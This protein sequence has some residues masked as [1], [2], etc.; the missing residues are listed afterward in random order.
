MSSGAGEVPRRRAGVSPRKVFAERLTA[1]F[2]AAGSPTLRSVASAAAARMAAAGGSN[3]AT[4]QRISDWRTGKAVPAEF[5]SLL[6][7]LLTLIEKATKAGAPA[8]ELIKLPAWKA[9]WRAAQARGP[10]FETACPYLGLTAYGPGDREW[11]FGRTRATAEIADLL[12]RTVDGPDAGPVV[13]IGASGAGK[14]S[15]L[16]AGVIPALRADRDWSVASMTPGTRP[17]KTLA[18][19][20]DPPGDAAERPDLVVIDQF[21]ETFTLCQDEPER[22]RFLRALAT[23]H[24]N[25]RTAVIL[26]VRADFYPHCLAYPVLED[27][28]N[29]RCYALGPMRVAELG[30]AITGPAQAAGLNFEPGLPELVVTELCGLGAGHDRRSYDPGGLPL[31]SHVMATTW[32]HRAG[33]RLTVA[34]YRKAGGVAGSVA[35]TAEQAWQALSSAEQ[36]AAKELLLHL[37]TVGVDSRDTRRRVPRAELLTRT[38]NSDA[39]QTALIRL[40]DAR[41]I[42]ADS[43]GVAEPATAAAPT[44]IAER[45]VAAAP[46]GG[47]EPES[48]AAREIVWFTHEIV[49][50]AWPRL[51]AWIDEGRVDHLIR[52]RLELDAAEWAAAQRDP[53]LLY[54]G[55]RLTTAEQAGETPGGVIGEFLTAAQT[56]RTRTRRL[57]LATRSVLALLGVGVLV[58][59]IAAYA[60]TRLSAQEHE[61]ADLV[62]TLA[63]ADSVRGTDPSLS[64]QLELVADRLHPGD[65]DIRSRLLRTQNLP[66]SAPLAGHRGAV[67][68]VVYRPDGRVLASA[69]QDG[70][71]RMWDVADLA[72]ATPLG[73]PL[74]CGNGSTATVFSPDGRLLAA[75]CGTEIRLWNVADPAHPNQLAS[76]GAGKVSALAIGPD[77]KTL[78]ATDGTNVTLWSIENPSAPVQ[79]TRLPSAGPVPAIAFG[80]GGLAVAGGHTVQFWSPGP[81]T[82]ALGAPITVPGPEIQAMAMSRDGTT[83]AV[84]GGDDA[85]VATG[86][87]DATVTLWDL[88][89]R[90]P[91]QM[92]S[93]L[94]VTTKSEL[95]SLAFDPEGSILATGDRDNVTLWSIVDRAHPTRLG[96]PLAAPSPPCPDASNFQPCRDSPS[97][98][99]FAADGHTVAVGGAQGGL[100]LWSL[101]PAVI[102]GRIGWSANSG[103]L[104]A[105]GTMATSVVDGRIELWDIHDRQSVRLLADLGPGPGRDFTGTPSLSD[106]GRLT[107]TTAGPHAGVQLLDVGDPAHVRSL[108]RFPDA[109]AGWFG[110]GGRVLVTLES[111]WGA[112]LWDLSDPA[113]PVAISPLIEIG[114][115]PVGLAG[116]AIPHSGHLMVTLAPDKNAAGA[117][118]YLI[119]LWDITHRGSVTELDR[120]AGDPAHPVGA[121]GLTPD[122]RTM[123]TLSANTLRIWDISDPVQAHPLGEPII[124]HAFNIQSVDFSPDG[125]LMATAGA[126]STVRLWDF[127]DRA[128]P[129]PL[130]QSITMPS[131]TTWNLSFDPAGGRL[132]GVGNSVMSIWDLDEDQA[133][134]RICA[135]THGV[136]TREVWAAH[137][138][139]LPYSP[140]CPEAK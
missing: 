114:S 36:A 37:V 45:P 67:K 118:E 124:G 66:L 134:Q 129:R 74:D 9:I 108:Y 131:H 54:Q 25:A 69:G 30:E 11:F 50:D 107:I 51:R 101:P 137:L 83:L 135:D 19:L 16:H 99:A 119:K 127:H 60:Q 53:A 8:P 76:P 104:S 12:R 113:Q 140:P 31:F 86:N 90:Q 71:V 121:F 77:G 27:A 79:S 17:S 133:R 61:N 139:R 81:T 109:I 47:A 68:Q 136:L 59:G 125:T 91:V 52:Q 20:L 7:V 5:E 23:L 94:V 72:H 98:L 18:E 110:Q 123:V 35:A 95:R 102:G 87:A 22:E 58:L 88:A 84:G 21:E 6:P 65:P 42:T 128:H 48:G 14:S 4:V 57:A 49:L 41:L 26:A 111:L 64:A 43:T 117:P 1:L 40:I 126:D 10:E 13:V 106:D 39:A 55:A 3:P 15:V 70:T 2:D 73:A 96:E 38:G 85:F 138:P 28:I 105:V 63:E 130:G 116:I 78:A 115:A 62:A 56:T 89:Q 46:A 92:G 80:P 132:I 34:G 33:A 75:A 122:E 82:A 103:A 44:G 112:R 32:Q 93:P 97:T 24:E 100:R 29:A 120:I